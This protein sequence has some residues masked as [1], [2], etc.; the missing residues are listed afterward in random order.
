MALRQLVLALAAIALAAPLAATSTPT[1]RQPEPLRDL[2]RWA[3]QLVQRRRPLDGA[4]EEELRF[5]LART[6]LIARSGFDGQRAVAL[7][8]V[9]L[10]AAGLRAGDSLDMARVAGSNR[11]RELAQLELRHWL[12]APTVRWLTKEVLIRP[13][14]NTPHRRAACA[15]VLA[16]RRDDAL[17]LAL[18]TCARE[19]TGVVRE[20]AL[21]A[22]AGWDEV[23][24]NSM[25]LR[26]LEA[27]DPTAPSPG[28][29][30]LEEHFRKVH[31]APDD[32]VS[33]RLLTYVSKRIANTDWR[34][35]VHAIGVSAALETSVV[36]P[37]LIEAFEVWV[38]RAEAG[39][40]VRRV[41]HELTNALE[42][43]SGLKLGPR[44]A[45]WRTWWKGYQ[46]GQRPVS[47]ADPDAP[48]TEVSFFGI[49]PLTDRVVFL[50]D[51]SGSMDGRMPAS[52][53]K[54]S[55]EDWTRYREAVAQ[56]ISLLEDMG[57]RTRFNVL[58]F[59]DG[60]RRWRSELEAAT[61]G[62]LRSARSWLLARGPSGGT[63]LRAGFE[64]A[65]GLGS[66]GELD[67]DEMEAD[68]LIILCD[69]QTAEGASWV[70]PLLERIQL[71]A[72]WLIH[73]VQLGSFGDDTLE[74][75]SEL[76]GGDHVRI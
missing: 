39:E 18:T 33:A 10:Y 40:P 70:R 16:G 52:R 2:E 71:E 8:L 62:N 73:T 21:W 72:R 1:E 69:G 74:L 54:S 49:R 31:L 35:A 47:G 55:A 48:V 65:I 32:P 45:R 26:L 28:L 53:G 56:M 37:L 66:D 30:P 57:S 38:E 12:D 34:A 75:L 61:P 5:L 23:S 64:E 11:V 20:A 67:L 27:E 76:T 13:G 14:E 41:H 46:A 59:D 43:R 68:T 36:S 4:G 15:F 25:F 9:D 60:P 50:I 17:L 3:D 58:T 24:V 51:H 63:Y 6:R 7:A 29:G 19:P 42:E 44:P 22:L